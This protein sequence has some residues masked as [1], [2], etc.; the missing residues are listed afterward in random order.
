MAQPS[1]VLHRLQTRIKSEIEVMESTRVPY[2]HRRAPILVCTALLLM[3][4]VARSNCA[5]TNDELASLKQ[6]VAALEDGQK[7]SLKQLK[8]MQQEL[9]GLQRKPTSDLALDAHDLPS[10][11]T[12]TARVTLVEYFDYECPYCAGF[13]DE[14]MPQLSSEYIAA[15][16]LKFVARDYPLEAN[17]PFALRAAVAAHCANEQGKFWPMHDALM[18]NSDA[19][20]RKNLSVYA[21]DVGLDVASFDKCVDS[22]KY[23]ADIKA[24][25]EEGSKLG[26]GGTPT[27]FL[28]VVGPDGKTLKSV[29]RFDGAVEYAKLKTAIDRLLAQQK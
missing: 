26:V 10:R 1:R 9:A 6:R 29:R 19:L 11:G 25:E 27:F 5:Q 3:L 4:A 7:E 20:D 8:A 18:G 12:E 17:H 13:F 16:K 24:S 22:E 14:T 15:G 28:G 23:A 21:K 2:R